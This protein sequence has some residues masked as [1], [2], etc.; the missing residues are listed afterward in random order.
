MLSSSSLSMADAEI[1]EADC[2]PSSILY[3]ALWFE[4]QTCSLRRAFTTKLV[5]LR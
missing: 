1:A 3:K 4:G 2:H 5:G